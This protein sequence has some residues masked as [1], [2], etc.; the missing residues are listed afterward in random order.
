MKIRLGASLV[1]CSNFQAINFPRRDFSEEQFSGRGGGKFSKR[2]LYGQPLGIYHIN[3]LLTD[4]WLHWCFLWNFISWNSFHFCMILFLWILVKS[5][6]VILSI[7]QKAF[8][9]EF[10]KEK[11]LSVN[12]VTCSLS[13]RLIPSEHF[14]KYLLKAAATYTKYFAR[15]KVYRVCLV[16]KKVFASHDKQH[17]S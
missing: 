7:I 4:L 3:L 9:N 11:Y 13:S 10:L 1:T 17:S 15:G 16:H 5:V 12:L 2:K 14:L 6:I 8:L